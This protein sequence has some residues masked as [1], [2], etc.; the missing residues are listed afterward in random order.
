[1]G[2]GGG[3]GGG[4]R[5]CPPLPTPH[6]AEE[7]RVGCGRTERAESDVVE[8]RAGSG[9]EERA[10]AMQE[11]YARV[12]ADRDAWREVVEERAGCGREVRGGSAAITSSGADDSA[13]LAPWKA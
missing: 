1:V 5:R 6:D 9:R 13:T 2:G 12:A 8:E 10:G 7:E 3:G 11:K 4:G